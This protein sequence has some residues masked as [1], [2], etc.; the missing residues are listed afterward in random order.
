[1]DRIVGQ[2]IGGTTGSLN[3]RKKSNTTMEIG[4]LVVC[5]NEDNTYNIMQVTE[6][7]HASNMDQG[8]I[9]VMSGAMLER[10]AKMNFYDEGSHYIVA[11]LKPLAYIRDG[12][13]WPSKDVPR[14]MGMLEEVNAEDMKFLEQ[15]STNTVDIGYLRSGSHVIND[16]NIRMPI[17]EMFTHHVLI[18]ASTGRGK[19]NL[20]KV[21]A[22]N[23]LGR[24]GLLILDAHNEYVGKPGMPGL[25]NHADFIS[26]VKQY[27]IDQNR[28][29]SFKYIK[30]KYVR[31]VADLSE[32]Q[33]GLLDQI[34]IDYRENWVK[35][36]FLLDPTD[37]EKGKRRSL[38][39]LRRKIG[40]VLTIHEKGGEIIS[41]GPFAEDGSD[42]MSDI[43]SNIADAKTVIINTQKMRGDAEQV[44]GQMAA[45]AVLK[46]Y[47][48]HSDS[49]QADLPTAV[50]VVEEATRV[51]S[52]DAAKNP[53]NSFKR[54]AREGRKFGVGMLAVT[55]S[56]SEIPR[57]I[58]TNMTT[59]IILGNELRTERTSIIESAS[60]DLSAD[61]R[62]IA[63]LA[64]GEAIISSLSVPFAIPIKIY[65]FMKIA[66]P[67][68]VKMY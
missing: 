42:I 44:I 52:E 11:D 46:H 61:D 30:T 60:Q 40:R 7:E 53:N 38:A 47:E 26:S 37:M 27:T 25:H 64:P 35:H 49:G 31:A 39:P 51:L 55:Q 29:I 58:L 28:P 5:R 10:N 9:K 24:V 59:K 22:Y 62:N 56:P 68:N 19:S 54:I 23:M 66:K 65:D 48:K 2:I 18:P 3:A 4:S 32:A 50:I 1:M 12:K 8:A 41:T 63:S 14:F 67:R 17:K 34:Y 43:V 45:S 6:M 57:A 36:L 33:D 21:M 16:V 20:V 15:G 13:P